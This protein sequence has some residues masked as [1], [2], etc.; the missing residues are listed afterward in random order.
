MFI[1]QVKD[2]NRYSDELKSLYTTRFKLTPDVLLCKR[3]VLIH[4][5][6]NINR[7]SFEGICTIN[8][9]IINLSVI[10][11]KFQY[12][13]M[14]TPETLLVKTVY[15]GYIT[16]KFDESLKDFKINE[17]FLR[18]C[19]FR[20][21]NAHTSYM[22]LWSIYEENDNF[23][24]IGVSVLDMIDLR[25]A[26]MSSKNPISI[27]SDAHASI[28]MEIS[29]D[30]MTYQ[31]TLPLPLPYYYSR[32]HSE[33]FRDEPIITHSIQIPFID[34]CDE[35]SKIVRL[36]TNNDENKIKTGFSQRSTMEYL[37]SDGNRLIQ[38]NSE[39]PVHIVCS[40]LRSQ[41][42]ELYSK[43]FRLF[44]RYQLSSINF[45]CDVKNVKF[46]ISSMTFSYQNPPKSFA[47]TVTYEILCDDDIQECINNLR[48]VY[49]D[50]KIFGRITD[51]RYD[52][53]VLFIDGHKDIKQLKYVK[54]STTIFDI[55]NSMIDNMQ[56][57]IVTPI[58]YF[59]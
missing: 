32:M 51:I 33:N 5:N 56:T 30:G 17:Q 38:T 3:T 53:T 31:P 8:C 1:T 55:W 4:D 12:D 19:N 44:C 27:Y 41:S 47:E 2:E 18:N 24:G 23:S 10:D 58:I 21:A 16:C 25:N 54:Y 57:S 40:L 9:T 26:V 48:I 45:I 50:I 39:P 29:F 11:G 35:Y 7:S 14:Y 20:L 59:N 43:I 36:K 15:N 6:I 42:D 46:T 34:I 52:L 37:T 49:G 22:G 13:A 28:K